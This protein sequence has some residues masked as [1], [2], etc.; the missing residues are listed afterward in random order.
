[1][2]R[3]KLIDI[4]EV[5]SGLSYR[6]Y[7]DE[8]GEKSSV[9]VQRS[10]KADGELK[11]FEEV[12][13]KSPI[14][15]RF[16]THHGDVLMKLTYPF[17]V[18]EVKEPGLVVSD[19]IAIIRFADEYDPSFFAHLLTNAHIRKQLHQVGSTERVAHASLK[20]IKELELIIPDFETQVKFGRL[21]DTI[22]EKVRED[23]KVVEYDRRL[24]E[25]ILNELWGDG[26][27]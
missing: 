24:K 13:L 1:M 7:L 15:E 11:D 26:D 21:L 4:A 8:D 12:R 9:I 2:L 10:I 3:K 16:Y 14:K 6:R 23:L 19:R 5:H 17:D 22:N 25:G 20:E 18:V 27:E